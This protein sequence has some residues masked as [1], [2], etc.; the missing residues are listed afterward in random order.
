LGGGA[1]VV[2][3]TARGEGPEGGADEVA[4]GVVEPA[5]HVVAAGRAGEDQL[6]LLAVRA[7][8]PVRGVGVRGLCPVPDEVGERAGVVGVR[9]C[10]QEAFADALVLECRTRL[11]GAGGPPHHRRRVLGGDAPVRERGARLGQVVA[12]GACLPH[13]L[14]RDP[15]RGLGPVPQPRGEAGGAAR[16]PQAV[17][18]DDRD[19]GRAD[20]GRPAG[21]RLE[22]VEEP[23][24]FLPGEVTEVQR[25]KA[26]QRLEGVGGELGRDPGGGVHRGRS[27][28]L[29]GHAVHLPAARG[30][31]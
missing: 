14:V 29:I 18:L 22:S 9:L 12:E 5:L 19:G 13:L 3:R 31:R 17:L 1:L 20:A 30:L 8:C 26:A 6:F 16:R 24:G 7:P 4:I 11:L 10:D 2:P 21:D 15:A 27:R 28:G 25:G 23:D